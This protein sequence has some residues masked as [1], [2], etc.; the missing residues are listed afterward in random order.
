MGSE[1]PAEEAQ[2]CWLSTML[3]DIYS[4]MDP[5]NAA[6]SSEFFSELSRYDTHSP[7]YCRNLGDVSGS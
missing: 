3:G 2:P 7:V 4:S 5:S 1:Q 6:N